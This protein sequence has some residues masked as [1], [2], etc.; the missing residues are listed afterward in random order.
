MK[1]Y[2]L[3]SKRRTIR[4]FEQKPVGE[5]LLLKYVNAARLAPSAANRQPLKYAV[6]HSK[7]AVNKVFDCVKWAG[8]LA[9]D[10]NPKENE[11]PTAFIAV[12]VDNN[13]SKAGYEMDIG[14]A[15][16][17]IILT[18]LEDGVGACWMGAID[19]PKIKEILAIPEDLT[20]SCVVALGYAGESPKEVEIK[21]DDI[22]YYLEKG[23][24]CV[25]KRNME[26]VIICNK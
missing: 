19:R 15:V 23:T 13:I 22:K 1:I 18:A 25:P 24:L 17:N 3:I 5:E 8:Y 20:L 26:E 7:E 9:P 16:E 10:Y 12:C 21:E 11:R 6:V 14:A 4:K 2:D